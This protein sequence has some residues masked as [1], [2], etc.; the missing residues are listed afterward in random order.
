YFKRRVIFVDLPVCNEKEVT[1][2]S[3]TLKYLRSD[4][5]NQVKVH[6]EYLEDRGW[7]FDDLTYIDS[8]IYV[9]Y[10]KEVVKRNKAF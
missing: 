7:I 10:K 8:N 6:K 5:S 2:L 1:V 4:Q 3:K 9:V